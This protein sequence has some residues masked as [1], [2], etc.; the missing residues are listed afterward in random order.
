VEENTYVSPLVEDRKA[1]IFAITGMNLQGHF[2][3]GLRIAI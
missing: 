3:P 2:L 1:R